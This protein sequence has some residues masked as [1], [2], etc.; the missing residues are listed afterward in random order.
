MLIDYTYFHDD[1]YIP[2]ERGNDGIA[3]ELTQVGVTQL[4]NA[5]ARFEKEYLVRMLGET[6]YEQFK[7]GLKDNPVPDK[8]VILK[9]VLVDE[10]AKRSPIANYIYVNY[11]Y[12]NEIR[13]AFNVNATTPKAENQHVVSAYRKIQLAHNDAV[14]INIHIAKWL[15]EHRDEYNVKP[16]CVANLWNPWGNYRTRDGERY[17]FDL[18]G[19][20]AYGL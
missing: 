11:V 1:L 17:L 7:E 12:R 18:F 19:T 4:D 20:E 6:L 9:Q 16:F 8:W 13:M 5:I 2:I 15:V 3:A 10:E 14:R